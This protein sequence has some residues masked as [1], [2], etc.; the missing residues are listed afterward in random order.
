M[1]AGSIPFQCDKIVDEVDQIIQL[2]E[3]DVEPTDICIEIKLCD[4]STMITSPAEESTKPETEDG[5]VNSYQVR[6]Y[7][8]PT[9]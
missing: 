9:L 3:K 1:P 2:I 6:N 8:I 7:H 5:K 4:N